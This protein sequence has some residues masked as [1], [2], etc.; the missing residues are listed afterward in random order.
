MVD[1]YIQVTPVMA[2]PDLDAGVAFFCDLLG[3]TLHI[4]GGGYA[5]LH[6]E[7]VGIRLMDE[8]I[9]GSVPPGNRRFGVYFDVWDVDGLYGELKPKLDLLKA[10]DVHG[11]ADKSYGQRE[12][13]VLG[14]DGNLVV[15][16]QEIRAADADG[17][18]S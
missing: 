4:K 9:T 16:G 7:T 1:R 3:F 14:P 15:F 17:S 8:S 2:V 6:R 18:T 10:G 11:P 12:L 5:Y 13:C